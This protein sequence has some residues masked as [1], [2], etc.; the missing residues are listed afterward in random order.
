MPQVDS[1]IVVSD[2][3]SVHIKR[4]PPAILTATEVHDQGYS[5]TA[6][7][8]YEDAGAKVVPINGQWSMDLKNGNTTVATIRSIDNSRVTFAP[9]NP[10]S[11]PITATASEAVISNA[12]VN[13]I[14]LTHGG[15]NYSYTFPA[16]HLGHAQRDCC[17]IH[18]TG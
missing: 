18:Y 4:Y 1:P 12:R 8:F 11:T 13:A 10:D 16:N 7:T 17:M 3:N 15:K 14:V 6:M 5:V 9:T 2:G